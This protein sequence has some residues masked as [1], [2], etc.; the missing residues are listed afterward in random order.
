MKRGIFYHTKK[1]KKPVLNSKNQMINK[2]QFLNQAD[3]DSYLCS[4][5]VSGPDISVIIS[6]SVTY[7]SFFVL[8]FNS[9][10]VLKKKTNLSRDRLFF[11]FR[12][13]ID[14]LPLLG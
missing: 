1:M 4:L 8:G 14:C 9:K 5:Y 3:Q 7:F 10:W 2:I 12:P 6:T 11:L 13:M